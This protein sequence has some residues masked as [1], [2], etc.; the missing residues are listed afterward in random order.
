MAEQ[1]EA[2]L[3]LEREQISA[4]LK[5]YTI[6][7]NW[8]LLEMESGMNN[9]TRRIKA[10]S[11]EYMLRIYNNH[12]EPS[13]VAVEHK[14]LHALH[15]LTE[16]IAGIVTDKAAGSSKKDVTQLYVPY[17]VV[18]LNGQTCMVATDGSLFALYHYI[19]GTRPN[20]EYLPHIAELGYAAGKLS[21]QLAQLDIA[22]APVYDPYW[23]LQESYSELTGSKLDEI[24]HSSPEIKARAPKWHT[25]QAHIQSI[26]SVCNQAAELPQQWI[27]GDI[28]CNNT[29]V[30]E[31][32]II[33]V[34]DF[35]FAAIDARAMEPAVIIADLLGGVLPEKEKLEAVS[36]FMKAFLSKTNL[37]TDELMLMPDLVKLR[38]LDVF[39]HVVTRYD[40]K[41]S[42]CE[43]LCKIID[44]TVSN[45]HYIE[46]SE[47]FQQ[48]FQ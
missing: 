29:L 18:G 39:L 3:I 22:C 31:D 11:K 27:H 38:L 35:E 21:R 48:I 7:Q 16:P 8:T 37:E 26:A 10:D 30:Q 9:T 20:P 42:S 28:V 14:L 40:S 4:R 36:V 46:T 43:L 41:L 13:I 24:L 19:Q 5:Q 6:S 44:D 32:R 45:I 1:L 2:E 25:L 34:L 47:A 15:A 33:A 12:R 23:K 17:P